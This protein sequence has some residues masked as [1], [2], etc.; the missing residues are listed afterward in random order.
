MNCSSL[1]TV[2]F[3]LLVGPLLSTATI[4]GQESDPRLLQRNIRVKKLAQ[5]WQGEVITL[6]ATD[7]TEVTGRLVDA[8]FS[9]FV[10]EKNDGKETEVPISQIAVV[11]LSP[12]LAELSLTIITGLLAGGFAVGFV[13]LTTDAS[14]TLQGVA[15]LVGNLTGIWMG[16][17][18][19][20]QEEVIELE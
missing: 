10:L 12:G 16:Y 11:T 15:A 17:F 9:R 7:G 5:I 1:K 19:F 2:M 6:T 4:S 13:S 8:N 3:I 20:Y 18:T 14:A